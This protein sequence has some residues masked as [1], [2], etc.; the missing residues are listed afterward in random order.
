[1][2]IAILF[3]LA[4][5]ILGLELYLLLAFADIV[6]VVSLMVELLDLPSQLV[7][8]EA[9]VLEIGVRVGNV[10]ASLFNLALDP[11]DLLINCDALITSIV[12]VLFNRL[13]IALEVADDLSLIPQ[14]VLVVSLAVLDLPL[15]ASDSSAE[16]LDHLLQELVI[17]FSGLVILNLISVRVNN[18]VSGVISAR[19]GNSLLGSTSDVKSHE[20]LANVC[21]GCI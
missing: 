7:V 10:D 21:S 12:D 8:V 16:V 17:A 20:V 9:H 3:L 18:A 1:L 6:A 4:E 14:S 5:F 15:E 11:L 19:A 13:K 2:V